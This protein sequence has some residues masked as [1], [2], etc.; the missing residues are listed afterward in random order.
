MSYN[1]NNAIAI[2]KDAIQKQY[3]DVEGRTSRSDFWHYCSITFLIGLIGGIVMSIIPLLGI[4]SMLISL[5]LLGPGIGMAVR[6][7]HDLGKPW[8]MALIP[9]YNIYLACQPSEPESNQF[10][11]NP[12]GSQA[13]AFS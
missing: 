6:R 2:F 12:L 5:A 7:M 1:F 4:V 8:W 9:F 11:P 13:E 10:G 3:W